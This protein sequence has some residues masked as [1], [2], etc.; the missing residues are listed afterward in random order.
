[1]FS[2]GL[3]GYGGTCPP[4]SP[5]EPPPGCAAKDEPLEIC[6]VQW[7]AARAQ[8]RP[9]RLEVDMHALKSQPTNGTT[10]FEA[11]PL[12]NV[13]S[14]VFFNTTQVHPVLAQA[15]LSISWPVESCCVKSAKS[16]PAR[17][18]LACGELLR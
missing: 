13:K 4:P 16:V 7:G 9:T 14:A 18:W 1:M 10:Q 2:K 15:G 6:R 3:H 8:R 12:G 17:G 11:P 5:G